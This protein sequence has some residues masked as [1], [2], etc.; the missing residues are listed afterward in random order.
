[1]GRLALRGG[2]AGRRGEER[3]DNSRRDES[4]LM[5]SGLF[6]WEVGPNWTLPPGRME[7]HS[8]S[9]AL[10]AHVCSVLSWVIIPRPALTNL[11]VI[12]TRDSP[13]GLRIRPDETLIIDAQQ[14]APPPDLV[15]HAPSVEVFLPLPR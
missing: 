15:P 14:E 3:R 13:S 4:V 5:Q 2:G 12:Q 1:M 11:Q 6:Q 10:L 8:A 7:S 9:S